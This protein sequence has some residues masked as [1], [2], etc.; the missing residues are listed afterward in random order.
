M[1]AFEEPRGRRAEGCDVQRTPAYER[2]EVVQA[3]SSL[4]FFATTTVLAAFGKSTKLSGHI[5]AAWNVDGSVAA[6]PP[7]R[8][9]VEFMVESLC[10]GYDLQDH[11]MWKLIDSKRFPKISADLREFGH[12][13]ARGRYTAAGQITLAGLARRYEGEFTLDRDGRRVTLKG[14]QKIDVRDFG[15]KPIN[16]LVLNVA[17][18]VRVRLHLVLMRAA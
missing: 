16:L 5:D 12:G 11:E 13:T 4:T 3:D 2:F 8:A 18:L 7:P 6:V 14:E 1:S 9:H 15:L 10:T 17:P